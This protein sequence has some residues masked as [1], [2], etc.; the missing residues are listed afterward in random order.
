MNKRIEEIRSRYYKNKLIDDFDI[1]YLLRIAEA[2]QE[3]FKHEIDEI[4]I[5]MDR[6]EK[7]LERD[8]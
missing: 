6:L 8:D 4:N 5:Y 1:E 3:L 2:S 7:A